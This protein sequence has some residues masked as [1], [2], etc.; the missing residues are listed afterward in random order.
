[1]MSEGLSVPGMR[2]TG[3]AGLPRAYKQ[4]WS[5]SG[6]RGVCF[7]ST[8]ERRLYSVMVLLLHPRLLKF[9]LLWYARNLARS[10]DT[11]LSGNMAAFCR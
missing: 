5:A 10:P 6:P 7:A 4:L 11:Q 2:G 9:L 3:G 8:I 1:M